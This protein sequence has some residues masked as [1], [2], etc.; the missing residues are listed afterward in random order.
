MKTKDMV[1]ANLIHKA[2]SRILYPYNYQK[3]A[4]SIKKCSEYQPQDSCRG[5]LKINELLQRLEEK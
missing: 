5:D 4:I 3:V 2:V 1:Q